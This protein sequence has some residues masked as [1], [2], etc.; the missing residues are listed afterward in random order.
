[1]PCGPST[2]LGPFVVQLFVKMEPVQPYLKTKTIKEQ[3]D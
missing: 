2:S 1:M 3:K